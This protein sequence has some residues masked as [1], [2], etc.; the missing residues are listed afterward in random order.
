[1]TPHPNLNEIY[2]G[3]A[4]AVL[5]TFPDKCIDCIITDPPYGYS[6]MNKDWDRAVVAVDTWKE[7]YRVLKSGSFAAVMSA[8][9]QDVLIKD[10]R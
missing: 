9:R 5:N 6:F 10:D 1:M 3:D 2:Q 7:C 8:P 4:L